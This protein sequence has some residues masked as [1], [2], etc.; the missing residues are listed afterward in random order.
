MA[1]FT[2]DD[3][4]ETILGAAGRLFYERGVQ[5]VSMDQLR[6]EAGVSLTRLYACFPSKAELVQAHLTRQDERWRDS[7]ESYVT[8]RSSDPIEQLLLVFDAVDARVRSEPSFR[9]CAF[10]NAFGELG[11]TS[12][13]ATALVRAHKQHLLEFLTLTARRAGLRSAAEVALQLMILAEGALITTAIENDFTVSGRAKKA[14][15]TLINAAADRP[16]Q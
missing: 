5:S 14:A 6:D 10:H 15:A 16:L 12:P 7:V 13:F 11:G 2:D 4:R 9:G 8:R 1:T 3:T